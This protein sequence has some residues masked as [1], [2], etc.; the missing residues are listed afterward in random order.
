VEFIK[1]LSNGLSFS[2]N[3]TWSKSIDTQSEATAVGSG[4]TN[5]NGPNTRLSRAL[6]LFNTPHRFTTFVS[7]QNPFFA[8]RRDWVGQLLGGWNTSVVYKA[9]YGSPFTVTAAGTDLDLDGFTEVRPVLIDPNI[10]GN[11]VDHPAS[12]PNQLPVTAFRLATVADYQSGGNILG[13]NTFFRDGV[14]NIDVSFYKSFLLP[15]E[16]HKIVLRA[17]MFNAFNHVRYALPATVWSAGST[18]FGR[19]TSESTD[20]QPRNVQFSLRY[21]F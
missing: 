14:N 18:T 17:D 5:A 9:A 6:S 7:F 3:Y 21:V 16:G 11:F 13:R 1:K 15:F 10:L 4:D 19:I 8:K 20:Y 2:T 12:S